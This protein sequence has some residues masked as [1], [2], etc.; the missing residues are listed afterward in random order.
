MK[1]VYNYFLEPMLVDYDNPVVPKISVFQ[2]NYEGSLKNCEWGNDYRGEGMN[3]TSNSW[4]FIN[5]T[6]LFS[7]ESLLFI[8]KIFLLLINFQL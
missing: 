8:L 2:E 7:W 6:G 3:L 4:I 1:L 5:K